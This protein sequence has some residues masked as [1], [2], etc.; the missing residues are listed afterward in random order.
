MPAAARKLRTAAD[1]ERALV[2]IQHIRLRC[3]VCGV[4]VQPSDLE[5]TLWVSIHDIPQDRHIC[6]SCIKPRHG[7][8]GDFVDLLKTTTNKIGNKILGL[9]DEISKLKGDYNAIIEEAEMFCNKLNWLPK[10]GLQAAKDWRDID[11][12]F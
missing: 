12:K 11:F 6:P 1:T 9:Q 10:D 8:A 2:F 7:Y 4:T 5:R 3:D